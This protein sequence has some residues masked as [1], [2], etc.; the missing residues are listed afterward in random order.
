MKTHPPTGVF[1]FCASPLQS[2]AVLFTPSYGIIS[3][4]LLS[5]R[6]DD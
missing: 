1:N 6:E 3:G 5:L 4:I 2:T